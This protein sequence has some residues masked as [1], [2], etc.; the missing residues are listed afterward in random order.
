VRSAELRV[1]NAECGG[2]S[3]ECEVRSAECGAS[4]S[5]PIAPIRSRGLSGVASA[6]PD[7]RRKTGK[8]LCHN[9]LRI[10]RRLRSVA[11]RCVSLRN[12]PKLSVSFRPDPS[13]FRMV[14][15]GSGRLLNDEEQ[16][17]RN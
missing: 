7:S 13:G 12:F 8:A 14:P 11:E 6:K 3:T 16:A 2:P 17:L 15:P 9:D 10:S 5:E 1:R 4:C